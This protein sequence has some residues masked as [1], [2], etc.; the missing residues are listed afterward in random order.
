MIYLEET[1][2]T[3]PATPKSVDNFIAIAQEQLIPAY[4]R[5]GT[6]LIAAWFSNAETL[7]QVTQLLEFDD[8]A[9]F[10]SFH[11]A[12]ANDEA[13]IETQKTLDGFTA[14]KRSRLLEPIDPKFSTFLHNAIAAS[15]NEE[16]KTFTYAEL[17]V[18]PEHID[19]FIEKLIENNSADSPMITS[20]RPIIGERNTIID[21]WKINLQI[22]YH[23]QDFFYQIGFPEEWWNWIRKMAPQERMVA[24]FPLPHSPLK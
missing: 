11:S 20:L 15:Q 10:E 3:V 12:T 21:I 8:L 23:P 16:I 22:G 4:E 1:F 9:A 14:N 17:Q 24:I 5:L 18:V 13:W 7:F 19:E 6:R 2:N